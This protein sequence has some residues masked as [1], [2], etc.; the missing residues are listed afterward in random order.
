MISN[1][2]SLSELEIATGFSTRTI[3]YYLKEIVGT[4]QGTAGAKAAYPKSVRDKLKFVALLK[5]KAP[6]LKLADIK[7]ILDT[8]IEED[9]S[10]IADGDEPLEVADIRSADGMRDFE[11]RTRSPGKRQ[12]IV[13]VAFDGHAAKQ[14]T[15]RPAGKP[16]AE[17]KAGQTDDW[18]TITVADGVELRV[19]RAMLSKKQQEQIRT[20][21]KLITSMLD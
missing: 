20:A 14:S 12:K 16:R 15:D 19:N 5:E 6:H 10:R 2:Y 17:R 9:I 3:R 11:M 18:T 8:M 13:K 21:G 1:S 4:N 7:R